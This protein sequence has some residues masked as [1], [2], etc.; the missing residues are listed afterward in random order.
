MYSSLD[1]DLYEE[2]T[3]NFK[4]LEYKKLGGLGKVLIEDFIPKNKDLSPFFGK[5]KAQ[6]YFNLNNLFKINQLK[7]EV[8]EELE[9]T[10]NKYFFLLEKEFLFLL[11]EELSQ[12]EFSFKDPSF[13]QSLRP[14]SLS[15]YFKKVQRFSKRT[16][17]MR[18]I[19]ITQSF[20]QT[21]G[22]IK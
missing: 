16:L 22:R 8:L 14:F 1:L 13:L 6:L 20:P 9:K 5:L 11:T 15:F 17:A 21:W 18:T 10:L 2:D 4:Q 3:Q 12:T 7:P 19:F